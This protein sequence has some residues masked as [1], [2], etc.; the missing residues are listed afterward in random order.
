MTKD[1]IK[2]WCIAAAV[3]ATKTAAQTALA[4]MGTTAVAITTLDWQQIAAISATA[5]VASVL[6]SIVGVPE[7]R[8]GE[9]LPKLAKGGDA[10]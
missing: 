9:S 3:R 6:T 1:A 10:Q 4:A 7:V 8:E 5:F 2:K